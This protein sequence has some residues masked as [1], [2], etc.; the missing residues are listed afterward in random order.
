MGKATGFRELTRETPTRR[1]T[2]LRV[3]DWLEVY[4]P[5]PADKLR[6]QASRC[7]D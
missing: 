1:P 6:G 2:E 4:E 7:M 5:F 3:K